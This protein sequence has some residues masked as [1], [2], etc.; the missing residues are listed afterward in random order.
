MYVWA[1]RVSPLERWLH[2]LMLK[3]LYNLSDEHLVAYWETGVYFPV[4]RWRDYLA[5]GPT[6]C[7]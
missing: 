1:Y 5:V 4:L 6:L 2:L 3:H 7:C